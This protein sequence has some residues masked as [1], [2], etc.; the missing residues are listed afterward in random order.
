MDSF[1]SCCSVAFQ[2]VSELEGMLDRMKSAQL[3]TINLTDEELIKDHMQFLVMLNI[4]ISSLFFS[5][6]ITKLQQ[7]IVFDLLH[8]S[9][10][11]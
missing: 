5:V 1:G 7:L 3:Q 4:Y 10:T 9:F 8:E 2:R 11:S 6:F